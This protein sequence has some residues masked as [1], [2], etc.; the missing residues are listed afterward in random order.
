MEFKFKVTDTT[1]MVSQ[2]EKIYF[3]AK[4]TVFWALEVF[5][6]PRTIWAFT[7]KKSGRSDLEPQSE[8]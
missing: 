6:S 2:N 3:F 8:L 7:A 4:I 5:R 1:T